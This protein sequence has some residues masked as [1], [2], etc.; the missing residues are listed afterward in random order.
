M[1]L[2]MIKCKYYTQ[3]GKLSEK[4][5]EKKFDESLATF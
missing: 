3:G 4:F 1:V 5:D 2:S